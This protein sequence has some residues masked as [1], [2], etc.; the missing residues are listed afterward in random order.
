MSVGWAVGV[1]DVDDV[2]VGGAPVGDDVVLGG[3]GGAVVP[4][5]HCE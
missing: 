1:D 4:G 2:E 3:G 5:R